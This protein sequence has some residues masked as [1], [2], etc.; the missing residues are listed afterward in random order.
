MLTNDNYLFQEKYIRTKDVS[1]AKSHSH[2]AFVRSATA[3]KMETLMIM[4]KFTGFTFELVKSGSYQSFVGFH[5]Q[6]N[7]Q[8]E[9]RDSYLAELKLTA[10]RLKPDRRLNSRIWRL[11]IKFGLRFISQP[12]F[13]Q[14]NSDSI[15][16]S[17]LP[18]IFL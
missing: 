15:L 3:P 17:M 6:N 16:K 4:V 9:L 1:W 5:H 14:N 10:Y 7:P 18:L 8:F 13:Y 12:L 11:C 2:T